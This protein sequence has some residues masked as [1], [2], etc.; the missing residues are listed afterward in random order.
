MRLTCTGHDVYYRSTMPARLPRETDAMLRARLE[1]LWQDLARH[2]ADGDAVEAQRDPVVMSAWI[3][4]GAN[5]RLRPYF[6]T[7]FDRYGNATFRPHR[8]E[9]EEVERYIGDTPAW[10]HPVTWPMKF[11]TNHTGEVWC[12]D[13]AAPENISFEGRM[14][15]S[16]RFR[17]HGLPIGEWKLRYQRALYDLWTATTDDEYA[18][19]QAHAWSLVTDRR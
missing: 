2:Q 6:T 3:R 15:M 1:D 18:V 11:T 16:G 8:R 7:E 17:P 14:N 10:H 5:A 4:A 12:S 19:A 9:P 13:D